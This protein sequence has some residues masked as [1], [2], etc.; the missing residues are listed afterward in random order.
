MLQSFARNVH[1]RL[2]ER[3]KPW[4]RKGMHFVRAD[5]GCVWWGWSEVICTLLV[6]PIVSIIIISL[7]RLNT[8][9]ERRNLSVGHFVLV[10][11]EFST[12]EPTRTNGLVPQEEV[13]IRHCYRSG[14]LSLVRELIKEPAAQRSRTDFLTSTGRT[15]I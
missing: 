5:P 3:K 13:S 6:H 9:P 11:S 10:G 4:Q 12:L 8:N 1:F 2:L 7:P 14:G 15:E